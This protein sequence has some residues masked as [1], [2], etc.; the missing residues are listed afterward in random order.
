MVGLVAVAWRGNRAPPARMAWVIVPVG[1]IAGLYTLLW[2]TVPRTGAGED[3]LWSNAVRLSLGQ[4]S[5][6]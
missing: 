4:L 6:D 5:Q 1:L 3:L 2:F